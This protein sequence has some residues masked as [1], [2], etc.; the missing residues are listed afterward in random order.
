MRA[1]GRIDL[2]HLAAVSQGLNELVAQLRA[3]YAVD[4]VYVFGSYAR[5]ELH[6]GSDIDML[7]I[8]EIPGRFHERIG[9]VLELTSLPVEPLVYTP[10]EA[11][12]LRAEDNPL[13]IRALTESQ[14]LC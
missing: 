9:R 12:Q 11:A 2:D 10:A 7:V 14:R 5:G 6:E 13:I 1:V 8:G 3:R 4:A